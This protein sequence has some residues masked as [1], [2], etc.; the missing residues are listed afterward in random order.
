MKLGE[1]EKEITGSGEVI[2]KL[3]SQKVTMEIDT[4]ISE[5]IETEEKEKLKLKSTG[6]ERKWT[7]RNPRNQTQKDFENVKERV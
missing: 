4:A 1:I 2:W 6:T 5:E 7:L 3:A